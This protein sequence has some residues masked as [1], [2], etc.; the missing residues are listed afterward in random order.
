MKPTYQHHYRKVVVPMFLSAVD[1]EPYLGEYNV[2]SL[3]NNG[4]RGVGV[5]VTVARTGGYEIVDIDV[6]PI[7]TRLILFEHAIYRACEDYVWDHEEDILRSKDVHDQFV[8]FN[9]K[10]KS[11]REKCF[12]YEEL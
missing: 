12:A 3:H 11:E 1:I 7:G 10:L 4:F 9:N 5:S 6:A 2:V 8:W